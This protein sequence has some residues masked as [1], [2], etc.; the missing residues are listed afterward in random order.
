M[1]TPEPSVEEKLRPHFSLVGVKGRKCDVNV[2]SQSEVFVLG[3]DEDD[4]SAAASSG[5][6][7]NSEVRPHL[8][9]S[10]VPYF[11]STSVSTYLEGQQ[12]DGIKSVWFEIRDI[13]LKY[14]T[15]Q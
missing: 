6:A 7:S 8:C 13:S 10:C 1:A 5:P 14:V 9:E 2:A 15:G 12:Y 11:K 3:V 4:A